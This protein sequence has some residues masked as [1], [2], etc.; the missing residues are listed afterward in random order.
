M[1]F[2]KYFKILANYKIFK[3]NENS[4]FVVNILLYSIIISTIII[5]SYRSTNFSTHFFLF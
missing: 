4:F 3:D 5:A 2:K 1:Y